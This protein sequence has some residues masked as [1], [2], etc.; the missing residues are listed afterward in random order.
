MSSLRSEPQNL[1]DL[2]LSW[3]D[4]KRKVGINKVGGKLA[5]A[6]KD[7]TKA[8]ALPSKKNLK[9]AED[10][11]KP[12]V[13]VALPALDFVLPGA[14]TAASL[15]WNAARAKVQKKKT[16]DALNKAKRQA[17]AAGTE[18]AET[19]AAPVSS[20]GGSGGGSGGGSVSV[21][22][23]APVDEGTAAAPESENKTNWLGWMAGGLL[24]VKALSLVV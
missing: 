19:T 23:L 15:A 11:A 3:G 9:K 13:G 20:A 1:G 10:S 22:T 4:I 14:G 12:V 5:K 17:A 8:I 18:T 21:T 2:G 6:H 7:V 16:K 24:A